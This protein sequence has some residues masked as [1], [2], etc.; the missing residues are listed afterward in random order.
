[1]GRELILEEIRAGKSSPMLLPEIDLRQ[2]RT[3]AE[4]TSAFL[5]NVEAVS[6]K[7]ICVSS[8]EEILE[9][10]R[11][12]FPDAKEIVSLVKGLDIGGIDIK[13]ISTA[14]EL[15]KLD[16]AVVRG[17][18]G[19]A[20]NGAVWLSDRDLDQRFVPFIASHLVIV[21]D[22]EAIVENMHDACLRIAGF[23][24]GYGV[25]VSGP[26][27]TADIEQSLVIGAQGP[28]SLTIFLVGSRLDS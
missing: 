26:S 6:G 10:L 13:K 18:F 28:L 2:F 23:D 16:L 19:V 22:G 14:A 15:D 17:Q 25:F 21:L 3:G 4:L 27:K 1:M 5:R 9:H 12:S 20:E 7:S 24:D 11:Q 8:Q